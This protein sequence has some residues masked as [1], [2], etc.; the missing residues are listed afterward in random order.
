MKLWVLFFPRRFKPV[1]S[2]N[3][4]LGTSQVHAAEWQDAESLE[5][6][7]LPKFVPGRMV[8]FWLKQKA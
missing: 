7:F 1:G 4:R 5:R 6:L 2:G 8:V 3:R